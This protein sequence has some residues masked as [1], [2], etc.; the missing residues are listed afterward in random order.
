[1]YKF[2][3]F[4]KNFLFIVYTFYMKEIKTNKQSIVLDLSHLLLSP[5]V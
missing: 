1:M 4:F 2:V 5:L 3:H